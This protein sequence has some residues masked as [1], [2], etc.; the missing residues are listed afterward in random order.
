MN[1]TREETTVQDSQPRPRKLTLARETLRSLGDAPLARA[2]GGALETEYAC[3]ETWWDCDT[4]GTM[5]VK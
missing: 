5:D 2:A 4:S 1:Q 3:Y